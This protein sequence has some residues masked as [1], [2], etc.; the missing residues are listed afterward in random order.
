[1]MVL[2]ILGMIGISNVPISAKV[3]NIERMPSGIPLSELD[4]EI[5]HFVN[6]FIGSSVPGAAIVIT[7]DNK[8][9]FSK[10][11]GYGNVADKTHV[12]PAKTVFEYGSINKTFVWT[13]VMQLVEQGKIEL[14]RDIKAY[15]PPSFSAKLKY[16]KPITMLHIMNHTAG[17]EDY[18]FEAAV[19]SP[20]KL[21]SLPEALIAG[22][23]NQTFEPGTVISYSNF[24]TAL[25][26][27]VVECV[28]GQMFSDYEMNQIL[29][30]L[31]MQHTSG[32]PA[33]Q[34]HQD[35]SGNKAIGYS[36]SENGGFKAGDWTYIPL[37]PSGGMNGT[38]EDLAKFSMA[39]ATTDATPLFTNPN[40]LQT[41]FKQ[42]YSPHKG[43]RSI[44]H[45]FW[46]IRSQPRVLA[47]DGNTLNFSSNLAIVPEEK[48]SIVVLTN[49]ASE[50][51][52]TNGIVNMLIGEDKQN[53]LPTQNHLP[54]FN[55]VIGQYIFA[56]NSHST[57][58]EILGYLTPIEAKVSGENELTLNIGEM[59]ATYQQISPYLFKLYQTEYASFKEMAP[60]LYIDK[61]DGKLIRL[62]TG[63]SMDMIPVKAS[64]TTP[65]L[66][67]YMIIAITS[68][69]FFLITPLV[70]GIRHLVRKLGKGKIS[71]I[72][73]WANAFLLCGSAISLNFIF[74]L[75]RSTSDVYIT[76]TEINIS[77]MLN[78]ILAILSLAF[79]ILHLRKVRKTA[80]TLTK[81]HIVFVISTGLLLFAFIALLIDWN[82]FHFVP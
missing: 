56:R 81:T 67:M 65:M 11:Y 59:T 5:D 75:V 27:Y 49:M 19:Q 82:F 12:D 62:T 14:D 29:V 23:P 16:D 26:A 44:A 63:Q 6:P 25:A 33:L 57:I 18:M 2:F 31:E 73:A 47:H 3:P 64:R 39:L 61:Q 77:I 48:L 74:I 7:K 8:I 37:Y 54:T 60:V 58:H 32:H 13:A 1:M 20:D 78:W 36:S 28:S 52:I 71:P 42:S 50:G 10:G 68:I 66:I 38:A 40:T 45:G 24:A 53:P 70:L 9:V 35:L 79:I 80:L 72:H 4:K 15:L 30:P 55:E 46:E 69:V 22:E 51:D 34:D 43:I 76:A 17:F 41:M 21:I